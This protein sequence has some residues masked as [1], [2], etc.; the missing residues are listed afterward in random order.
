MVLDTGDV[1]NSDVETCLAN[2]LER[3]EEINK[4][5]YKHHLKI[6]DIPITDTI[7]TYKLD[8]TGNVTTKSEKAQLQPTELKSEK[9]FAQATTFSITPLRETS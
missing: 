6:F 5:F 1:M 7:K 2:L 8:L 3:N 9:T 4:E